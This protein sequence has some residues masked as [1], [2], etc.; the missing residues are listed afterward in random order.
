M[1]PLRGLRKIRDATA[2]SPP[3]DLTPLRGSKPAAN[4]DQH[5]ATAEQIILAGQIRRGE[6]A[7]EEPEL[8]SVASQILRAG[9]IRRGEENE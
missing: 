2:A 1:T 6:L 5:R 8:N 7:T 9:R 4:A 3:N